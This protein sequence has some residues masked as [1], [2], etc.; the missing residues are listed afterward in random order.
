MCFDFR[1]ETQN[2]KVSNE[3]ESRQ[4]PQKTKNKEY[5]RQSGKDFENTRVMKTRFLGPTT[6]QKDLVE[7]YE[8]RGVD[9][10]PGY[11]SRIQQGGILM[12]AMMLFPGSV[13]LV[14]M[15]VIP[16]VA[17]DHGHVYLTGVFQGTGV[18]T[19]QIPMEDESVV[20][21]EIQTMN[22]SGKTY[23]VG[24]PCPIRVRTQSA[25]G[26]FSERSAGRGDLE[27]GDRVTVKVMART[28]Q[29]ITIERWEQ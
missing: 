15:L 19:D 17:L 14:A 4:K 25:S 2:R 26:I 24:S 12:R 29:E 21:E 22:I 16:A 1:G 23:A 7:H 6:Q 5:W 28:L 18:F 10:L 8:A 3:N 9:I 13:F 27:F 11:P 20:E